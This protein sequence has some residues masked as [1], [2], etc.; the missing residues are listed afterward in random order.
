MISVEPGLVERTLDELRSCGATKQECV[1]YWLAAQSSP[2]HAVHLV[3]PLHVSTAW[4]YEIDSGWLT[5]FMISL[6]ED[7]RTAIA[8]VHTH[9]GA[10]TEHSATDNRFALIPSPG[11]VSVVVPW[12]AAGD[13]TAAWRVHVLQRDG[14]WIVDRSA[15]S[16]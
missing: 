16:W 3:H 11:Y 8:Q 6:A 15:I 1:V 5:R 12:F 7:Y 2:T 13:E 14:S 10:S 4:G 9:P